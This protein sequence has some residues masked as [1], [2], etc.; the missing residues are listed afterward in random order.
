M[1]KDTGGNFTD[2][3]A[4]IVNIMGTLLQEQTAGFYGITVPAVIVNTS[5]RYIV[6]GLHHSDAAKFTGSD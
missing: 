2:Q 3:V 5:I 1:C 6:D 4:D